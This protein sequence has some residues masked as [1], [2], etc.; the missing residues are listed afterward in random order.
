MT[1][2]L[3]A[4]VYLAEASLDRALNGAKN[5][6][7]FAKEITDPIFTARSIDFHGVLL[8]SYIFC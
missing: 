7:Q 1:N 3:L 6:V 2:H 5:L 4:S 8:L